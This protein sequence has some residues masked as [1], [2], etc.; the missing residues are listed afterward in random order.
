MVSSNKT[1]FINKVVRSR[2]F[3]VLFISFGFIFPIARVLT[4]ELPQPL[5]KYGVLPEFSLITEDNLNIQKKDLLGKVSVAQ[6]VFLSCPTVCKKNMEQMKK[7]QKRVRGLGSKIALLSI[8]VDPENDSPDKMFKKAR[9]LKANPFVWKFITGDKSK[10]E[11]LLVDGFKVPMGNKS[12]TNS[13]YDIAHSEKY[14]V[15]DQNGSIRGYYGKSKDD[16]NK[17]MIDIGLLINNAFKN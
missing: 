1:P 10:I 5:P 17:M 4:R 13:I 14:V 11:S 6:F 9:S 7:I 16:I 3:W 8:T 2:V 15:I 12:Y